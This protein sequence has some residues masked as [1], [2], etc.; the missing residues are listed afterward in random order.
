FKERAPDRQARRNSS[1]G[2]GRLE[3]LESA[4]RGERDETVDNGIK[5]SVSAGMHGPGRLESLR[6]GVEQLGVAERE[7]VKL[8]DVL[9]CGHVNVVVH[10][11][12]KGRRH[13]PWQHQRGPSG[14]QLRRTGCQTAS[15]CWPGWLARRWCRWPECGRGRHGQAGGSQRG[16]ERMRQIRPQQ[17][18]NQQA[19]EEQRCTWH[20]QRLEPRRPWRSSRRRRWPEEGGEDPG[21]GQ[22]MHS[23]HSL[24]SGQ[25][26]EPKHGHKPRAGRT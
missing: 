18:H 2:I 11:F 8:A 6:H 16:Q 13:T 22:R 1:I 3:G 21:Q 23:L 5:G 17:V 12:G 25:A 10:R 7:L 26:K 15:C 24:H 14:G 19:A 20:A 9:G 4:T